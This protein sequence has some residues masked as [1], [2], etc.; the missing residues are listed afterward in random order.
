MSTACPTCTPTYDSEYARDLAKGMGGT[1]P[2]WTQ[3]VRRLWPRW[4]G[5]CDECGYNGIKYASKEHYVMGDW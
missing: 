3:E 5:L 1:T 4:Y 2:A